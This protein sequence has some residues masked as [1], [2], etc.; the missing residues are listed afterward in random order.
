[1]SWEE[2]QGLA[3]EYHSL[4][5]DNERK[6]EIKDDLVTRM[7]RFH[8]DIANKLINGG[9]V[10]FGKRLCVSK[11][12]DIEDLVQDANL[13]LIKSFDNYEPSRGK[14]NYFVCM[15][16]VFYM[17]RR[18]YRRLNVISVPEY[19]LFDSNPIFKKNGLRGLEG[20]FSEKGSKYEGVSEFYKAMAVRLALTGDYSDISFMIVMNDLFG[21][22]EVDPLNPITFFKHY[23]LVSEDKS[24]LENVEL[25]DVCKAFSRLSEAE[26]IVLRMRF[27]EGLSRDN[28]GFKLGFNRERV[29]RAEIR[30]LKK[31]RNLLEDEV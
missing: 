6:K 17:V 13:G 2:V 29:R 26:K 10:C 12:D 21:E 30:G 25:G 24:P 14:F 7:L 4:G 8:Y 31:M 20:Y 3:E 22:M 11:I 9:V 1:M 5:V 23:G 18:S 19:L 15:S 28:I 16:A 27:Y